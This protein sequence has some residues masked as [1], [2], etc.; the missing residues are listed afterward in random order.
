MPI[1]IKFDGI[2]GTVG[3][4]AGGVN[5]C[6]GDGSVRFVKYSINRA[7]GPKFTLTRHY[8]SDSVLVRDLDS[9]APISAIEVSRI[10]LPNS[11]LAFDS[12][13]SRD[14]GLFAKTQ[15]LFNAARAFGLSGGIVVSIPRVAMEAARRGQC[16]NNLKQIGLAMHSRV[17][18]GT[19]IF[20]DNGNPNCAAIELENVLI[21]GYQ[22]NSAGGST[23]Q[24]RVSGKITGIPVDPSSGSAD[25]YS[26]NFSKITYGY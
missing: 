4:H 12:V 13:D 18:T 26:L 9:A 10:A 19:V 15:M 23:H 2:N 6:M 1:F 14:R 22:V 16:T 5:V 21:T 8:D 7:S 20:H 17:P 25:Q 11:P 24:S 3:A